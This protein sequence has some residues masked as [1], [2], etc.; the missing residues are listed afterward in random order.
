MKG[1]FPVGHPIFPCLT[2]DSELN[3]VSKCLLPHGGVQAG[4]GLKGSPLQNGGDKTEI[5]VVF[6]ISR[7]L[8]PPA[9][10]SFS[11]AKVQ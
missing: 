3:C 5:A 8:L 2:F 9:S 11:G 4:L 10:V 6:R 1:G 7:K